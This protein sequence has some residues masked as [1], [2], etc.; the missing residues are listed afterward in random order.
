MFDHDSFQSVPLS[1]ELLSDL[2]GRIRRHS[3]TR[4]TDLV[5]LS[6]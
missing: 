1:V 3:M 5:L 4:H 2:A 6:T